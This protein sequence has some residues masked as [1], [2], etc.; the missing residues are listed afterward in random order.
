MQSAVDMLCR[1]EQELQSTK[2]K[3]STTREEAHS[4]KRQLTAQLKDEVL[5]LHQLRAL[6]LPLHA[7]SISGQGHSADGSPELRSTTSVLGH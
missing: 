2:D 5:R 4:H 3:L 7:P 6:L 1:S